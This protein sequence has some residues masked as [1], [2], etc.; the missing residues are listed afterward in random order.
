[1][2]RAKGGRGVHAVRHQTRPPFW[3][4][5][6]SQINPPTGGAELGAAAEGNATVVSVASGDGGSAGGGNVI[7]GGGAVAP[8]GDSS[9]L[10][11][12]QSPTEP[13]RRDGRYSHKERGADLTPADQRRDQ[14]GRTPPPANS[15][16]GGL[17]GQRFSPSRIQMPTCAL[18]FPTATLL[19]LAARCVHLTRGL[20]SA[21]PKA[22]ARAAALDK[23]KGTREVVKHSY[24]KH[25]TR[26][27]PAAVYGFVGWLGTLVGFLLYLLWAYLPVEILHN[28]GVTY[29]PSRYWAVAIPA[30]VCVAV[31]FIFTT[32]SGFC[33]MINPPVDAFSTFTDKH[34]LD[35][36]KDWHAHKP[37]DSRLPPIFDIPI[38]E[39]NRLL[40][41]RTPEQHQTRQHP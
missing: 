25:T 39:V 9:A 6:K 30:Y 37:N 4:T 14:I 40:Y 12:Q 10:R 27:N 16:V 19:W 33:L 15:R 38:A 2:R 23:V 1:M 28:L 13:W 7:G 32:Y 34:A 8:D 35:K 17:Q 5:D 41:R 22:S 26:P 20:R 11:P 29:Y 36:P 21:L 18:L 31:V 3:E 24:R